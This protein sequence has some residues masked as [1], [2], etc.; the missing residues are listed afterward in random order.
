[1][2]L[3]KSVPRSVISDNLSVPAFLLPIRR[4]ELDWC[5]KIRPGIG[6]FTTNGVIGSLKILHSAESVRFISRIHPLLYSIYIPKEQT[7]CFDIVIFSLVRYYSIVVL[8]L[9]KS[10]LRFRYDAW[11]HLGCEPNFNVVLY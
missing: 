4:K 3:D 6:L 10:T 5:Y 7:D 2:I 9:A 11:I 8:G 1:M